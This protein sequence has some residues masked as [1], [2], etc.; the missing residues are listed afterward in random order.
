MNRIRQ[1]FDLMRSTRGV[2]VPM[3]R[4]LIAYWASTIFVL[5]AAILVLA[6]FFGVFTISES[7]LRHTLA[8]HHANTVADVKKQTGLLTAH[9]IALSEE[10]SNALDVQL[11]TQPTSSL[12]DDPAGLIKTERT[13]LSSLRTALETSPCNGAFAI[14][15]AT[16]N[17]QSDTASHSRAGVYIRY[18]N[19]SANEAVNQD[20]VLYRGIPQIA[21]ESSIEMHNRWRLEFDT[22]LISDYEKTLR[23]VTD[24][25]SESCR[26]TNRVELT[27]TWESAIM[28]TAPIFGP[29]GSARGMCGLELSSLYLGLAYPAQ[30]SEYG[31]M[32]TV[33][34]PGSNGVIDLTRGLTGELDATYLSDNDKLYVHEQNG[35]NTYK[36]PSGSFLGMHTPLDLRTESGETMYVV[37]LVPQG[38]FNAIVFADRAKIIIASLLLLT[39]ALALS[40]FL[41]RRFVQPIADALDAIKANGAIE[42]NPTGFSEIDALVSILDT[43]A[44]SL[45]PGLLPPDVASLLDEFLTRFATLTA[46]ERKIVGLYAEGMEA[47]D[48]AEHMFISIHTVRKHNANIYR[49]L[50]VGSREELVLY[51]ELFRR[52]K[53]LDELF[54]EEAG[55]ETESG[56][57]QP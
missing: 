5:F 24:R 37:T 11:L 32:A 21:R 2:S 51:L 49:K 16:I 22:S 19:L 30:D 28:I 12:D 1:M 6:S 46:T 40:R 36:A 41:S 29:S 44:A 4:K 20:I 45:K 56:G 48:V 55:N 33:I 27:D 52:C 14:L 18:A 42:D 53:K 35:L 50:N 13:L 10:M 39:V 34:A 25:V 15:D 9:A 47:G 26:W 7:N 17:T 54:G 23:H 8:A 31:S 57:D 43:K 38:R 3:R